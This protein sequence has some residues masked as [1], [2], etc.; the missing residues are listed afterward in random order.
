MWRQQ[1]YL[2]PAAVGTTQARDYFGLSVAVSG[3]TVI[4]GAPFEDS[5]TTGVNT[6]PND[7]GGVSFDSGAAYI[8]TGFDPAVPDA[9]GDGSSTRGN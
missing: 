4:V 1:A 7:T 2:K 9:D 6:T 5:N 8:F 3:D